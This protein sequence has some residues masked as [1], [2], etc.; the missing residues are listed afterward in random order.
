MGIELLGRRLKEARSDRDKTLDDIAQ[1]I[2]VARSTVQ[3]YEAG[4]ISRPKL[5][6]VDAMAAYLGVNRDWLL[7]EDAPKHSIP[8]GNY[9]GISGIGVKTFPLLGGIA[10]GEP[11]LMEETIQCYVSVTTD[12]RADFVL[13]AVGASMEPGIHDGDLVFVKSQ[14]TVNNGQIA[15][16]AIGEEATLKRVYWYQDTKTLILRADNPKVPE[17]IY[18]PNTFEEVRILGRAVALQRDVT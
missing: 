14:P 17:M 15:A 8:V 13:R 5:P 3:R 10:C 9:S 12:L 7:G 16:V 11:M 4:L 18:G 6:V 2:G 1:N